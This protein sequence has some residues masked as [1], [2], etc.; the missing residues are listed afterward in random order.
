MRGLSPS[1]SAWIGGCALYAGMGG[2]GASLKVALTYSGWVF[3]GAVLIWLFNALASV[4]RGTGNM[5]TP[6]VVTVAGMLVLIPLSPAL[7]F[8]FGP[9]PRLGVAGG[10][11]ALLLYY[12]VGT[13]W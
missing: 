1:G 8:G 4:V 3:A 9:L 12:L 2:T 6:A 7:I 10:A 11:I 13:V 5:A